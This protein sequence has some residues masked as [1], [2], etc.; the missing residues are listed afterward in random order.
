MRNYGSFEKYKND[1]IGRNSR[2]DEIQ[3]SFLNIK[4]KEIESENKIRKK[5]A[6]RYINN[7]KN[8]NLPIKLPNENNSI[9]ESSWHLFVILSSHRD[10]LKDFLISK[11]IQTMFHYP[12]APHKQKA[13]ANCYISNFNLP[14]SE[15]IHKEC[16]SLPISSMHN[17]DEIDYV[18][19][20]LISFFKK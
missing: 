11:G 5:L 10:E 18:S 20:N 8:L 14:I 13:F 7:L 6:S 12:I 1:Q 3:A 2:L 16:I 15:K 17:E 9:F 4:L 19:S